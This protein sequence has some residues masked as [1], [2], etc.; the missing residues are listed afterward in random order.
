MSHGR[1]AQDAAIT[2]LVVLPPLTGVLISTS[3]LNSTIASQPTT[4]PPRALRWFHGLRY[5]AWQEA[6]RITTIDVTQAT[7][8]IRVWQV[9]L[10]LRGMSTCQV[11]DTFQEL[12]QLTSTSI[13]SQLERMTA[14]GLEG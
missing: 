10:R 7:A 3:R 8:A 1:Q 9:R 14:A 6:K 4:S 2:I 11:M 13:R 12:A 5:H